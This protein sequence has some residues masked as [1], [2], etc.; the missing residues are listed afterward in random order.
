M[1]ADPFALTRENSDAVDEQ[2]FITLGSSSRN[3]ILV[4]LYT[5]HDSTIRLVSAWK[6]NTTHDIHD[7]YYDKYK[8]Y[9]FSDAKPVAE[10]PVLEKLQT[11]EKSRITR[12]VDNDILAFSR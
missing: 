3:W 11:G 7:E 2:R 10:T 1:L 4:V 8:D 6:A 5:Y 12:Q 9:D